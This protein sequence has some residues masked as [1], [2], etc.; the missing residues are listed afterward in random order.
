MATRRIEAERKR[1]LKNEEEL[2]RK[3]QKAEEKLA[4]AETFEKRKLQEQ[5]ERR[6]QKE[7]KRLQAKEKA[8]ALKENAERPKKPK[9]TQTSKEIAKKPSKKALGKVTAIPAPAPKSKA[10]Q[11]SKKTTT[12]N[13]MSPPESRAPK[14]CMKGKSPEN[15]PTKEQKTK[16]SNPFQSK[17]LVSPSARQVL[18]ALHASP[19]QNHDSNNYELSDHQEDSEWS[20]SSTPNKPVPTWAQPSALSKALNKQTKDPDDIFPPIEAQ[21]CNL[22]EIFKGF[23]KKRRFQHRS[24]SGNWFAD[25]LHWKEE[26]AYKSAMGFD[27]AI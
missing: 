10:L 11:P 7:N 19:H 13:I 20:D 26:Q 9:E 6:K 15:R 24:S 22:S 8:N 1:K 27:K 5:Q 2:Q 23:R 18:S 14:R 25:R 3:K 12:N 17:K 4:R 16:P 21:A